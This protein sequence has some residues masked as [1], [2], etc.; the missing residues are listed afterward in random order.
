MRANSIKKYLKDFRIASRWSTFNGSIQQAL[1]IPEGFDKAK[2]AEALALLGQEADAELQCVYCDAPAATWDHLYNNVQGGR[3]SGHGNRIFNLVPACRTCNE[4]KGAKHWREFVAEKGAADQDIRV[5][6]L[7]Q[8]EQRGTQERIGWTEMR[9]LFP[10]L[11]A[12]YDKSR[13]EIRRGVDAADEIAGQLRDAVRKHIRES[14]APRG[15]TPSGAEE[16]DGSDSESEAE[17]D[18]RRDEEMNLNPGESGQR[19]S[20]R[21][22]TER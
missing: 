13:E 2:V 20:H 17:A 3:Y 18:V 15:A 14:A 9:E 22:H 1:A 12:K 21:S 11:T 5:Q 19:N 16:N 10:D 7:S 8:F 6:R 4:S